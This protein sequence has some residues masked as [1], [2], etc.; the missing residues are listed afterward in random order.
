MEGSSSLSFQP[1][2]YATDRRQELATNA[3]RQAMTKAA[4]A[5]VKSQEGCNA[6]QFTAEGLENGKLLSSGT[7]IRGIPM[8]FNAVQGGVSIQKDLGKVPLSYI[9]IDLFG[10]GVTFEALPEQDLIDCLVAKAQ[11]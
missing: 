5:F 2:I 11:G 8:Q 9:D 6:A 10:Y 1:Q 4:Q 7:F 3:L